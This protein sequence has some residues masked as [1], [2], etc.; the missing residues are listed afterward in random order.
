[1]RSFKQKDEICKYFA[2]GKQRDINAKQVQ[3]HLWLHDPGIGEYL[4]DK[5]ALWIDFRTIDEN[6]LHGTGGKVGIEGGG[7]TL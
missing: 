6:V 1:M 4:T 7:I 5:Y 2:K 3:K